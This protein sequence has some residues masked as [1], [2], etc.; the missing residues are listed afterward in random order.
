MSAPCPPVGEIITSKVGL[1]V[2]VGTL[3]PTKSTL[4]NVYPDP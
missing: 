1:V 3:P 2:P 4:P